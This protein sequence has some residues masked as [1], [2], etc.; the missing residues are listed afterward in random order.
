MLSIFLTHKLED[1]TAQSENTTLIYFFC[2]DK[3]DNRNTSVAIVRG[4]IWQHLQKNPELFK[5]IEPVVNTQ[6]ESLFKKSSFEV[7]WRIFGNVVE[8]SS[9]DAAQT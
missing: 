5:H 7:L 4:V 8:D 1:M 9:K 6:K 2:A 3:E